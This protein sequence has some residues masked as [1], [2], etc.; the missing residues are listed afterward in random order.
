MSFAE[1]STKNK[2]RD[3]ISQFIFLW[4]VSF[5]FAKINWIDMSEIPVREKTTYC[6][7]ALRNACTAVRKVPADPSDP[8]GHRRRELRPPRARP[9]L[10]AA[11]G[12]LRRR[13]GAARRRTGAALS[14]VKLWVRTDFCNF[15][16]VSARKRDEHCNML[17]ISFKIKNCEKRTKLR[18]EHL[19]T[20]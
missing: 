18:N 20:S 13:F 16:Q 1:N 8:R 15:I 19:L 5:I 2:L 10:P 11:R 9:R 3:W 7:T 4:N 12:A 6:C 17:E 14:L